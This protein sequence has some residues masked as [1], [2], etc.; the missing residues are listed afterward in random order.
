MFGSL[1][2]ETFTTH[3]WKKDYTKMYDYPSPGQIKGQGEGSGAP[4]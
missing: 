2:L 1:T 3:N 4:L